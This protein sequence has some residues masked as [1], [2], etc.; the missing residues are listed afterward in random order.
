MMYTISGTYPGRG[1]APKGGAAGKMASVPGAGPALGIIK[2]PAKL[3]VKGDWS[4]CVMFF[5]L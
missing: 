4:I 2:I 3:S 1:K 5:M